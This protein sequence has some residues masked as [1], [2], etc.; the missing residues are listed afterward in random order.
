MNMLHENNQKAIAHWQ[1]KDYATAYRNHFN[2]SAE[3]EDWFSSFMPED[4]EFSTICAFSML[5][6]KFH[7]MGF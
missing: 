7:N 1:A 2:G 6:L 3:I 5:C 4:E